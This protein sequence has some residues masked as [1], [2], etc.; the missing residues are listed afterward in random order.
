[1]V[2]VFDS[3]LLWLL[4]LR[5]VAAAAA[6]VAAV[7][8]PLSAPRRYN[9]KMVPKHPK[10]L[11]CDRPSMGAEQGMLQKTMFASPATHKVCARCG[12]CGRRGVNACDAILLGKQWK[13]TAE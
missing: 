9:K 10:R 4:Q 12:W 5:A 1:M 6:A 2:S 8:A 7:T 3:F 11:R 13:T